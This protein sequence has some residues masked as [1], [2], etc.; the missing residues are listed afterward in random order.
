VVLPFGLILAAGCGPQPIARPPAGQVWIDAPLHGDHLPLAPYDVVSHANLATG[1]ASFEL[2]VNGAVV[3]TDE[4]ESDQYG[5]SLASVNQRWEPTAP[6]VYV[7]MVRAA[8]VGG[9][10]GPMAEIQ[11]TVGG[12]TPTPAPAGPTPTLAAGL[13]DISAPEYSTTSLYYHRAALAGGSCGDD[14]VTIQVS[15]GDPRIQ[16]IVMFFRMAEADGSGRTEWSAEAM[17]PL[18]GGNYSRT[19]A[20]AD[21]PDVGA[22]VAS[23]LQVQFVATDAAGSEVARSQVFSDVMLVPCP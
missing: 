2:S 9:E 1:V 14:R 11:V 23:A 4:A 20:S 7:L 12:T 5:Q 15:A 17:N 16:S 21:I 18:G 8:D 10:F 19:L 22:F 6:G 13:A 3:R